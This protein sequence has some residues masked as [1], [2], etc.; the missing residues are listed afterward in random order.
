MDQYDPIALRMAWR[1]KG[2]TGAVAAVLRLAERV[3]PT[4]TTG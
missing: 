3:L 4:P 1:D 2:D